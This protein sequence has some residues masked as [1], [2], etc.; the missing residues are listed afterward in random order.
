[1]LSRRQFLPLLGAPLFAA[2]ESVVWTFDNLRSIGGHTPRIEGAPKVVDTPLGKATEFSGA[3]DALF[4]DVHPLAGAETFTWEVIFRPDADGPAAQRFFHM[5]EDGSQHRL[6]FETRIVNG[7]WSL[8][9]F[10]DTATGSKALMDLSIKH[11]GDR[12]YHVAAVYDG[13]EYRNY[14]N[15]VVQVRAN[16]K[17]APQGPGKTSVGVRINK[18]DYF[19]GAIRLSRMTKRAL[20]AAE[21]LRAG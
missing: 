18:V 11:P 5:Q 10:A 12:W 7:Q 6:L 14:V 4:F 21:F 9:S 19:K 8:D 15:G 3:A 13:T 1:M 17:L 2:G 16:V 20:T